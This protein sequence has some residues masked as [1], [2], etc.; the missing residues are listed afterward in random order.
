[1]RLDHLTED[2]NTVSVFPTKKVVILASAVVVAD[3][4]GILSN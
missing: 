3:W 4:F 1:M 2:A